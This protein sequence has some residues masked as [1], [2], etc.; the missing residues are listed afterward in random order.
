ML[1]KPAVL[2]TAAA[3]LFFSPSFSASSLL[4]KLSH[5]IAS[6]LVWSL[7][8]AD[9]EEAQI[10]HLQLYSVDSPEAP[11]TDIRH[12]PNPLPHK[13]QQHWGLEKYSHWQ[14]KVL[15]PFSCHLTGKLSAYGSS[16][17]QSNPTY[18]GK[19]QSTIFSGPCQESPVPNRNDTGLDCRWL[20]CPLG[21]F[22]QRHL[23]GARSKPEF[24]PGTV[25]PQ[26]QTCKHNLP[27]MGK[28]A[29]TSSA[30]KCL[31]GY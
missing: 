15:G 16:Q 2:S 7:L 10:L 29:D 18:C 5:I 31:Y 6:G 25:T 11:K 4:C 9:Q 20:C 28:V 27:S 17:H 19:A 23:A 26:L 13:N 1:P 8:H 14:R 21:D 3:Q 12:M 22:L 24:S 30:G